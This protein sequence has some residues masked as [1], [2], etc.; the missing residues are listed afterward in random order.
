MPWIDSA[1]I[2]RGK[3][4]SEMVALQV[5]NGLD[6]AVTFEVWESLYND[7][8]SVEHSS[9]AKLIYGFERAMQAPSFVMSRRGVLV[10]R[11][12]RGIVRSELEQQ[13]RS[14]DAKFQRLAEAVWG[15]PYS[16]KKPLNVYPENKRAFAL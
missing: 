2:G 13:L 11:M 14:L 10:D 1:T 16:G 6:S 5:Y 8:E 4:L 15:I 7:L 12:W 9:A 3:E